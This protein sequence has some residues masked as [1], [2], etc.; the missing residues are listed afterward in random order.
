VLCILSASAMLSGGG[1]LLAG[2]SGP[3][4]HVLPC[5]LGLDLRMGWGI[6]LAL[7]VWNSGTAL[8]SK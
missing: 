5:Q 6:F 3:S 7:W 8:F 1:D 4:T 2:R